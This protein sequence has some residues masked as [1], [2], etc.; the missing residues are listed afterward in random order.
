MGF[1]GCS[2]VLS[3][4][5]VQ[6]PQPHRLKVFS[7]LAGK[8]VAVVLPDAD[9]EV[10]ASELTIGSLAFNGQ[11]RDAFKLVFAHHS[12]AEALVEKLVAQ[13]GSL[14]CG[15][16]WEEDVTVTPLA[17]QCR[18][19]HLEGLITDAVNNGAGI[20]NAASGGGSRAGALVVPTV[21]FPVAAGARLFAED[22][23]GPVV[24]IATYSD[25]AELGAAMK[26]HSWSA[27]QAAIFGSS[28]TDVASMIDA[29]ATAVRRVSINGCCCRGCD[30][31]ARS[32]VEALSAFSAE[33]VV[34][35]PDGIRNRLVM[36]RV[37]EEAK[38]LQ[39]AKRRRL[40]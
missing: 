39:P 35:F 5:V 1:V 7:R 25:M 28:G 26:S 20:A 36:E 31:D 13:V 29:L 8:N 18:P 30:D 38:C 33:T 15:M 3:K 27:P 40:S 9:L 11:R 16:P 4:L 12:I 21:V 23:A 6:H 22:Q 34:T 24:P 19:E 14:K 17:E 10:A 32:I 37:E 2:E